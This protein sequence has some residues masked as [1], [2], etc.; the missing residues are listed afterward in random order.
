MSNYKKTKN[1]GISVFFPCYNDQGSI[2]MVVDNTV[3]TL[4]KLT[5]DFEVIVIDDGSKDSSREILKKYS[6][7]YFQLKLVFHKKNKG[8]GGALRS[9][10]KAATKELIFYTDGDGQYDVKELP[11]LLS[12]LTDDVNFI[13]GIKMSRQDPN[14]RIL[15]GNIYSLIARWMFWLPVYDVDCDFRLIRKS[16][17]QKIA[18]KNNSGAICIELVKKAQ[19]SGAKFRQVSV[20]HYKRQWGQSQFF[21]FNRL[22]ATFRELIS[23]W[24]RLMIIEK[25]N[26]F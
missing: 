19:R 11:I 18:L 15:L 17:V 1:L 7:K 6:Q 13:N 16:V 2:G 3:K 20:H 14:Y 22:L 10:F 9:G 5:T 21:H 4:K 24:I 8:Y 25:I 12:L 26:R 23:L